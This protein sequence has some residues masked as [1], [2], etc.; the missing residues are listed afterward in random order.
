MKTQLKHYTVEE[1]LEG[2]VYNELEGKGLFGLGG[3]LVIQP[4][5]QRNYIYNDGKRDVAVIDSLLKE[6]PLG[7]IYFNDEGSML[8]VLDG[9]QR[10]T[11]VGRF[12][13]GKFAIKL[14]GKEQTF[15]SLPKDLQARILETRLDIYEC[16]G[17]EDEIKAWFQTINIVGVPLNKQEL[18]NAVYSGPF[19]TKAKAEY[20]NSNNTNMQKWQ[21]YVNGDP[22]RQEVLAVALDWVA[23]SQ[24][25]SVDS[26]LAQYRHDADINELKNYFTSVIDWVSSVFTRPPDREM[27]GLEWGRLYEEHHGTSYSPAKIEGHV[28]ELRGDTAVRNAKGIYEYLLGGEK[29]PQLL[30]IRLF[31]DKDKR[32]AYEQQTQKAKADGVSNCPLCA[33]GSDSNK[34]RIYKQNEMDADHVTAWSKGG[35]TDISN[36]TML[37]Q[38]HN[39]AKG[40]K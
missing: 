22:K 32:V 11:S 14:N 20:S 34:S 28:N 12:V 29:R 17:S 8:E 23:S 6:Y 31:D 37:C 13:T 16:D 33:I 27:R 15:S 19:I 7:L 2:F 21:S 10:I 18:L 25:K 38:T 24:G 30:A 35:A 26:Y 40:N 9:Q 5:Y 4:E 39:R 36:L 3:R 1:I